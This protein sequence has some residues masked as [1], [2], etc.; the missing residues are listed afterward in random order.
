[1]I[2]MSLPS[3]PGFPQSDISRMHTMRTVTRLVAFL[4]LALAAPSV[5]ACDYPS[6]IDIPSGV[7]ATKEEMLQAQRDVK[8]YVANM[9]AYLD[10]IV[11]EEKSVRSEMTDLAPEDEQQREDLLNKKY[12]AAVDEMETVAA[13]FNSEVQA[14]RGRE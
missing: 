8:Q 4:L 2:T 11:A 3:E 6:R 5:F 1:M 13:A 10:C 9:E 14:Y 12:N 7:T